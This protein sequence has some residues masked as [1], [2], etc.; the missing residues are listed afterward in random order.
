MIK[1]S[2]KKLEFF[3]EKLFQQIIRLEFY[4]LEFDF[5]RFNFSVNS[6]INS[7]TKNITIIKINTAGTPLKAF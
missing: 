2:S 6:V 4:L 3:I 1:N 7:K 5:L